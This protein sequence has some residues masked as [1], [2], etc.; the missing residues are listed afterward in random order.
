MIHWLPVRSIWQGMPHPIRRQILV[1]GIRFD[2]EPVQGNFSE[3]VSLPRFAFVR[4]V[5]RQREISA[6][7]CEGGRHF[8]GSTERMQDEAAGGPGIVVQEI[9]ES[10]PCLEAM[11]ADRDFPMSR[12]AQLSHEDVFLGCDIGMLDP[13]VESDF[14]ES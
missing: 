2:Q 4:E 1:R 8:L 11:D 9:V 6:E 13:S 14:P 5:T 7:F 12:H 3:G 10:A